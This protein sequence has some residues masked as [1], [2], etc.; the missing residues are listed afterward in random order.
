MPHRAIGWR[1]D[2]WRRAGAGRALVVVLSTKLVFG[3]SN[4]DDPLRARRNLAPDGQ[5]GP[6][7]PDT[8]VRLT[9]RSVPAVA[10]AAGI[11]RAL[12]GRREASLTDL[13]RTVGIYKSTAHGI[14]GTLS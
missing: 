4:H 13:A 3:V 11:L 14:L 12:A 8:A 10:R 2:C 7:V 9:S 1:P 5:G 6:I